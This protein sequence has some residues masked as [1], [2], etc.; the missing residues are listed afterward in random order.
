[1]T[2]VSG[3]GVRAGVASWAADN[4]AHTPGHLRCPACDALRATALDALT[5]DLEFDRAAAAY[6]AMRS[7]AAA[8]GA[9]S[10]R[11]VRRNTEKGYRRHARSLSLFFSGLTLGAIEWHHMRAYQEARSAGAPPFIRRRRPH[12]EPG[13]CPVKPQQINQELAFLKRLKRLALCWTPAD[14]R[15]YRELQ[16]EESDAQRALTPEEQALWLDMARSRERWSLIYWYS[17]VAF[18]TTMSTNELRQL[19][20][21]DVNLPH[22]LVEVPWAAAKNRYRRR[23]IPVEDGE[24]LWALEELLARAHE[25]GARQPHDYLFPFRDPRANCYVPSR[26]MSESGI[27]RLWEEVRHATGLTWFRPYDTRHTGATRLAEQG[28]PVDVMMARMG[29]V[30][31]RMRTHYVHIAQ[32]VQRQW[33]RGGSGTGDPGRGYAPRQAAR[34]FGAPYG[35]VRA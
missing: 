16:E 8:P 17:L 34:P 12:E 31:E 33:L 29:H 24:V 20:L 25:L 1:M 30:S 32:S 21:C 26:H 4:R 18:G 14:D 27:K 5:S 6:M 23:T 2:K 10:A 11:Y 28:V 15:Y 7:I 35:R 3:A 19:R 9:I 22:R 13:P